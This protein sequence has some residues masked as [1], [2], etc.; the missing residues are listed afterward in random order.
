MKLFRRNPDP[1]AY[2]PAREIPAIRKSICT[3]EMTAGLIDRETGRFRELM[4]ISSEDE[5][6]RQVGTRDIRIIY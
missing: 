2:D 5:F 6:A 1:I 3:G 4:K